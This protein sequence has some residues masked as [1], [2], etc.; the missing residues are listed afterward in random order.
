MLPMVTFCAFQ[1]LASLSNISC[2]PQ[3]TQ[4]SSGRLVIMRAEGG[5]YFACRELE[6][7]EPVVKMCRGCLDICYPRYNTPQ[8]CKQHC[9]VYWGKLLSSPHTVKPQPAW[10][11]TTAVQSWYDHHPEATTRPATVVAGE[12]GTGGGRLKINTMIVL[13]VGIIILLLILMGFL[14]SHL[15]LQRKCGRRAKGRSRI[16]Q[17]KTCVR[18]EEEVG[19]HSQQRRRD[20][21]SDPQ[22]SC[23]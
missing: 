4:R 12:A 15:W 18:V 17:E 2:A 5:C 14:V 16:T 21:S 19:T 3:Y 23:V 10:A 8:E 7:C 13:G 9:P 1:N 11:M 6:Y 22:E 20:T